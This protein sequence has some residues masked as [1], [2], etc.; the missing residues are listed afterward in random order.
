[1]R[2]GALNVS[3]LRWGALAVKAAYLNGQ[4]V[5]DDGFWP[6]DLFAAGEQ[7]VWY[8]PSDLSTLFQDAGG[9]IPV[10]A[11]GQPVGLMLDK[12]GRG[13]HATQTT[14]TSRPTLQQDSGGRYC[15][16]FDGVDDFL[17]T[18]SI[19][20]TSTDKV[21][22]FAGVRKIT[23][24]TVGTLFELSQN[25]ATNAGVFGM[26][27]PSAS[28]IRFLFR[29]AGTGTRFAIIP[30]GIE[31]S[32]LAAPITAVVTGIGEISTDT[33]L[34]SVNGIAG[35]FDATD[36]G[37]GNYGNYPIYIGSRGGSSNRFKGYLYSLI[38]RGAQSSAEQIQSAE[39]WVNS[40]TGAY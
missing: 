3:S 23:D 16:S 7:G 2:F 10:I 26:N 28:G 6:S 12:S 32:T 38:I 9:T 37:T 4:Q 22:V 18:Q 17:V 31:Y 5:F 1:M 8:D 33:S 36:Q 11:T 19:N 39:S 15:L 21:T 14:A 29:S 27:V 25:A 20:F 35:V 40:K 13:H 24:D 30:F 34:I